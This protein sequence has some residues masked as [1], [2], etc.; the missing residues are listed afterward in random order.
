M[1]IPGKWSHSNQNRPGVRAGPEVYLACT[2]RPDPSFFIQ[3]GILRHKLF[4]RPTIS[5]SVEPA[6]RP[7]QAVLVWQEHAAN[8]ERDPIPS[9][10]WQATGPAIPLRKQECCRPPSLYEIGIAWF[11]TAMPDF[12]KK[13]FNSLKGA[14]REYFHVGLWRFR[15]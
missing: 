7:V 8:T 1:R 11:Y 15:A 12:C 3:Y 9:R 10:T 5:R 4:W 6:C 2:A 14:F 13:R